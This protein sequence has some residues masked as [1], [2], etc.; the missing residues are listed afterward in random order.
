MI[1]RGVGTIV[2]MKVIEPGLVRGEGRDRSTFQAPIRGAEQGLII[3]IDE[4]RE[5]VDYNFYVMRPMHRRGSSAMRQGRES[6]EQAP[7]QLSEA[8]VAIDRQP[9]IVLFI[10]LSEHHADRSQ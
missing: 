7:L 3:Q 1:S 10:F 5:S 4:D 8:L 9:L 2:S 6:S